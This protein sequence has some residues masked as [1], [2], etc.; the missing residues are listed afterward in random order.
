LSRTPFRHRLSAGERRLA[1]ALIVM[2]LYGAGIGLVAAVR[3]AH[4]GHL[5]GGLS[6]YDLWVV[7]AGALG[8]AV[9]FWLLRHRFGE[10]G[11][12]G[13]LRAAG[14]ALA[15]SLVA[16]VIG[17][18]LALPLYG[19]MFGPFTLA[20]ILTGAP[21]LGLCWL[22]AMALGHVLLRRLVDER[23]SIFTALR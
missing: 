4:G 13:A 22:S 7:L 23:E 1:L 21:L 9:A 17:G 12:R 8:T 2:A 18:T 11:P 19:T 15:V 14:G 20:V 10:A 6:A 3:L 5:T 16:P